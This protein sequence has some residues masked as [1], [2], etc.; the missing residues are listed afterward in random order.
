MLVP[1]SSIHLS[2]FMTELKIHH[3]QPSQNVP[4]AGHLAAYSETSA[5]YF[6]LV[7]PA[8]PTRLP[9]LPITIASLPTTQKHFDWA[10]SVHMALQPWSHGLEKFIYT[11]FA[12]P[13]P[14]AML[15][16]HFDLTQV[17][18]LLFSNTERENGGVGT[19]SVGVTVMSLC[20]CHFLTQ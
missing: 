7:R 3:L 14:C 13:H 16:K 1:S 5:A 15:T 18:M 2:H 6:T 9:L 4:A 8:F 20:F 12:P 11:H 19:Y 10:A 17:C